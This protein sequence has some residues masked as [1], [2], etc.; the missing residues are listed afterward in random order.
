MDKEP[1]TL[2]GLQK[3]KT[4][5]EDLKNIQ[6]PKIVEAIAEARS[7]GVLKENAVDCFLNV[8]QNNFTEEIM[9]MEVN[10]ELST[11]EK[12]MYKVGYKPYSAM[13]DYMEKCQY[14][15]TKTIEIDTVGHHDNK[16]RC[17]TSLCHTS[18]FNFF[19]QAHLSLTRNTSSFFLGLQ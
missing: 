7:H 6:R 13:C 9:D 8:E 18:N 14:L 4:E 2:N 17:L 19:L 11:G 1:I 16:A 15:P 5:L 10:Q 3:L 12:I